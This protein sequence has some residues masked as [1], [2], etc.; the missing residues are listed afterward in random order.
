[1]TKIIAFSGRKQSGKSSSGEF[2][3]N[4]IHSL[5]SAIT[6]KLYSF[7]DPL[8]QNICIDL[9]GLTTNQCYGTDED[10]NSLTSIKWKSMPDYN[11]SW[12]YSKDYDPSGFM[13]ARQ[14]M[15]FVGTRIF[16]EI[17]QDIWV[18]ATIRQIKKDGC[19]LAII[20]DTRFPD[21]VEAIQNAGGYVIRLTRDPFH[22]LAE[23]EVALD[24]DR[25]DW[26]K[27]SLIIDNQNMTEDAKN[28][29][30]ENFLKR[31]EF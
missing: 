8:K 6:C 17:K 14:V 21:E 12:T 16:R 25:Y 11:I 22:S 15:E 5:N 13:T 26:S 20:L 28:N 29:E 27:F 4:F 7:A 23:P 9:L 19:D 31:M 18:D 24:H 3:Q 1:M 2:A 10:K 30:I